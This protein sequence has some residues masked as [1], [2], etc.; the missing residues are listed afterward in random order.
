MASIFVKGKAL[1]NNRKIYNG[2]G[3]RLYTCEVIVS[4]KDLLKWRV[5]GS[6]WRSVFLEYHLELL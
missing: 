4:K 5:I 2:C 1:C 3:V 6:I